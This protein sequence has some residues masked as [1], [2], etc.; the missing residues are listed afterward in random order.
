MLKKIF[1][2]LDYIES[3]LSSTFRTLAIK[4]LNLLSRLWQRLASYVGCACWSLSLR[5]FSHLA[6]RN[7][8]SSYFT[9]LFFPRYT[10]S[11]LYQP[12]PRTPYLF[13]QLSV[14]S[15]PV[16]SLL[17]R[18][19]RTVEFNFPIK[20]E[21]LAVRR[22]C[23]VRY[24]FVVARSN[25]VLS[26]VALL[27]CTFDKESRKREKCLL[28]SRKLFILMHFL[29]TDKSLDISSA[30]TELLDYLFL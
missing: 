10:S 11:F 24:I 5:E 23:V 8:S 7:W 30:C 6:L 22:S 28:A 18:T 15:F 16:T 17:R 1:N 21:Y 3:A 2:F 9:S 26:D 4:F 25:L 27:W 13:S 14:F 12:L 19:S 20:I 29:V